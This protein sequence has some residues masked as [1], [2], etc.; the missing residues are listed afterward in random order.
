MEKE[1]KEGES[2]RENDETLNLNEC[3]QKGFYIHSLNLITATKQLTNQNNKITK[4]N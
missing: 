4:S 3:V 2:D 1:R